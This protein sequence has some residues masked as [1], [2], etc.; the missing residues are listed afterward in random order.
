MTILNKKNQYLSLL[1]Y[2]VSLHS[3]SVGIG[4]I[5]LPLSYLSFFGF[6]QVC[7]KFFPV[8]GGVFHVVMSIAYFLAGRDPVKNHSLVIFSIIV[9]LLATLFLFIYYL[10]V[11]TNWMILMSGCGDGLMCISIYYMYQ[12]NII[13]NYPYGR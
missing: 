13:K 6:E 1:L 7:E 8:Q 5:F 3:L 2:L 10:T 12:Q 11:K 9:K 4:L